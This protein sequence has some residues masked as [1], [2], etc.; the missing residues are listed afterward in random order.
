M[1]EIQEENSK[2]RWT[3]EEV[4]GKIVDFEQAA[5]RLTSQRQLA[6]EIEIP[7]TTLQHCPGLDPGVRTP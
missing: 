1:Q 3:R 7:R 2:R 5:K 6:E 4:A